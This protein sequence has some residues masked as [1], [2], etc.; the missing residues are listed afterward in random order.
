M[1]AGRPIIYRSCPSSGSGGDCHI[2][3]C[4]G[5]DA[6]GFFHFNWGW[7]GSFDGYFS[8]SALN[9]GSG[10]YNSGQGA[11]IGIEPRTVHPET[12]ITLMETPASAAAAVP[13]D[14]AITFEDLMGQQG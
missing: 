11:L 8:L 2:F 10:E 4:D 9:P 13:A 7:S 14:K 1:N 5:Y 12:E 3:N 6:N